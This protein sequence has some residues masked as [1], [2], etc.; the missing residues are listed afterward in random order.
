MG[1]RLRLTLIYA[2]FCTAILALLGIVFRETLAYTLRQNA[3]AVLDEEWAAVKG[4]LRIEK[5]R[6]VWFYDRDD[7]EEAAI[8]LKFRQGM[9]LLADRSGKILEASEKYKELGPEKPGEIQ[10]LLRGSRTAVRERRDEDGFS[11]LIK[12]GLQIDDEKRPYFVAIGRNL[13][14]EETVLDNFTRRYISVAPVLVLAFSIASWWAAGRALAPLKNVAGAAQSI[15]GDNLGLRIERRGANDELDGM[16]DSFNSM[17]DRL[18]SSFNQIRQFS[19]DVS[20][21]LRTPLTAIRGQLEVALMTSDSKDQYRD[22][23]ISAMEDVDR[24]AQVVRALLHLSQAESGQVKLAFEPVDLAAA[25]AN[26]AEQFE[27]PAEAE[28][29]RLEVHLEP[30]SAIM[31]DRIQ[32]DR[33]LSNLLS[34]SIKYTPA[35]GSIHLSVVQRGGEVE[36]T[37]ADTGRG[38]PPEHLPHIFDR[39]YR[40]PDGHRDPDKGLG[41]GLSFVAWIVK[42]HGARIHVDSTPGQGTRFTIT[43]AAAAA[44]VPANAD[45]A[46]ARIGV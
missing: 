4:Y 14:A 32:L 5:Q 31:G 6:P 18:Q 12:S 23:M 41:L 26:I 17:V 36:L 24:L 39:F 2:L 28:N 8:V 29:L 25:A 9:F 38:I 22:A 43:F 34:N 40:V 46:D 1:L 27:I 16:I 19:T 42:A 15:T 45:P 44:P 30:Q 10:A 21:E 13:E 11:Y 7:D 37:V 33:L 3:T 35:G 20:H